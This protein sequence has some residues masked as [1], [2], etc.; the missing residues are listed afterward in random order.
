M[1]AIQSSGELPDIQPTESVATTDRDHLHAGH[2]L[3]V[4]W[5]PINHLTRSVSEESP[6]FPADF[7]C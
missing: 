1:T 4:L 2:I 3:P 7:L 5:S 6:T